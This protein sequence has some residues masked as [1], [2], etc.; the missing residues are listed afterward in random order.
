MVIN[1]NIYG[2]IKIKDQVI[3]DLINTPIFQRLKKISQDGAPHF[4]QPIRRVTRYEHSIGVWYLSS[5]YKRS[6]EEQIACLLHDLSHTAFSHVIDFVVKNEKQEFADEKLKEMIN[7]SNIPQIVKNNGFDLKKILDKN[8]FPLL[9]NSLPD[10]SVDRWDYFMR[11][12]YTIGFLPKSI[13]DIFLSEIFEKENVFYFKDL[14]LAST[15]AILFVNFSRLIW[16]DPTSHGSFF[17]IAEAIKLA[18]D[19][20]LITE[21]DFFTDDEFLLVKLKSSKN[22]KIKQLLDRLSPGKEFVYE[23]ECNAEFFGPNKPRFVDPL[24]EN[25]GKLT[26]VSELVPSLKFFFEEFVG[27]YKNLGVRQLDF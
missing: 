2:N 25:D 22:I 1:D 17:L 18:L 20:K 6:M 5:L 15:F 3:I 23:D 16:L 12:G 8:K 7:K 27:K 13:I 24:V 26:R 9:E 14:K 10:I 19:D 21:E 4:I 11:D